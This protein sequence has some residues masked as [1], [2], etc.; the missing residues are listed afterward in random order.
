MTTLLAL[1]LEKCLLA[2]Y[3]LK[4]HRLAIVRSVGLHVAVFTG[5]SIKWRVYPRTHW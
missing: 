2:P 3:H 4:A 1:L 5:T